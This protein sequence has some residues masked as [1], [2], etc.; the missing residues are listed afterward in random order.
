MKQKPPTKNND[1]R[2]S[3]PLAT[4]LLG[5]SDE[6]DSEAH[7]DQGDA[8]LVIPRDFLDLVLLIGWLILPKNMRDRRRLRTPMLLTKLTGRITPVGVVGEVLIP[9]P[10][11]L[12]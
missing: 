5:E 8:V 2:T 6:S 12:S 7:E 10:R 11:L 1:M 9:Y 4:P 3:V